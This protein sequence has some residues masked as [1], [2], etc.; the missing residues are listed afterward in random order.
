MTAAHA[1]SDATTHNGYRPDDPGPTEPGGNSLVSADTLDYGAIDGG[2][3]IFDEPAD[4][5]AVW[6]HDGQVLW[7]EG[8]SLMIAGQQGL[9]KTTLGGMVVRARLGL[10]DG[11]VLGLPVAPTDHPVLYLAMDRPRQIARAMRRQFNEDERQI[12]AERL[13]VRRGPPPA[14]LAAHPM[15]LAAMAEYYG[16]GTV[17]VDS[18]KD[19]A[20]GL[21]NDEVGASWNRARQHLLAA[22]CQLCELH[23]CV[24]RGPNGGEIKDINDVYGSAWLTNGCGSVILLTGAPGDPIVGFRHVKQPAE[25]LGPWQLAHDQDTG[26]MSINHT[27]DLLALVKAS[28][29]DGLTAKAAAVAI[30]HKPN[31]SDAEVAKARRKLLKLEADGLLVQVAGTKGGATGGTQSA[32]FLAARDEQ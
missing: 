7:A 10:G 11:A 17:F 20:L 3:F 15:L 2:S 12:L 16:A 9:G 6:G 8:E 4:V 5:P 29:V 30:C 23:H 32:W 18:L 28:G 31:P 14:D 26:E 25:E 24:K 27:Y 13:I 21:S 22:G 1:N 19:A